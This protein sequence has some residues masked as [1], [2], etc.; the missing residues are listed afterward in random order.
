[1]LIEFNVN[2]PCHIPVLKL[3]LYGILKVATGDALELK[4]CVKCPSIIYP[5]HN[6]DF[7]NSCQDATVET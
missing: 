5:Q 7:N 2:T 3:K 4:P 1:M 6:R